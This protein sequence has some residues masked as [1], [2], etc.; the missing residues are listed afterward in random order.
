[1]LSAISRK[2]PSTGHVSLKGIAEAVGCLSVAALS[3]LDAE[4]FTELTSRT[5]SSIGYWVRTARTG[6]GIAN[7]AARTL[8]EAVFL[9]LAEAASVII[10]MDQANAA[11]AAIPQKL[12]FHL[13][14]Y[15]FREITAQRHAGTGLIWAL[16]RPRTARQ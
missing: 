9:H 6:Q 2:H 8:T 12:G 14:G 3:Y 13:L 1:L 7:A 10:T 5:N 16:D 11:S 4:E 15:E